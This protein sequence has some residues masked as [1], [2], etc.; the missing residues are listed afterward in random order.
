ME[1]SLAFSGTTRLSFRVTDFLLGRENFATWFANIDMENKKQK[2]NSCKAHSPN[3]LPPTH[4]LLSR[5]CGYR[6]QHRSTWHTISH[7][8]T[9]STATGG[10]L[11]RQEDIVGL[12][13]R[14]MIRDR[15]HKGT[16]ANGWYAAH[17][18]WH[19]RQLPDG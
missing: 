6:A 12:I 9:Q 19:D 5:S 2:C 16:T 18:M 4:A 11:A 17:V 15:W 8:C 13:R 1:Q 14:Y 7:P 10:S 3:Q